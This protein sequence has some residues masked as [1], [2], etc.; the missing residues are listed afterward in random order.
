ML[1]SQIAFCYLIVLVEICEMDFFSIYR[2]EYTSGHVFIP[3][4]KRIWYH[5]VKLPKYF[6]KG[7]C[8]WSWVHEA[9]T[10]VH[11]SHTTYFVWLHTLHWVPYTFSPKSNALNE[12]A[13][14]HIE[15]DGACHIFFLDELHTNQAKK[16]SQVTVEAPCPFMTALL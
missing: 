13:S 1:H 8:T 7:S 2:E 16:A 15:S 12:N 10:V 4:L 5:K 6:P 11:R 9:Y 14:V 3:R